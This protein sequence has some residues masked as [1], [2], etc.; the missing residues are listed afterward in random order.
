[1]RLGLDEPVYHFVLP[2]VFGL[3]NVLEFFDISNALIYI[4]SLSSNA[5]QKVVFFTEHDFIVGQPC[6]YRTVV[7]KKDRGLA[8]A[9][10]KSDDK[11][12]RSHPHQQMDRTPP[13]ETLSDA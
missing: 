10:R 1:M 4:W 11:L 9:P 5:V 8:H 6:D 7:A 3:A 13:Q 2:R 12:Q